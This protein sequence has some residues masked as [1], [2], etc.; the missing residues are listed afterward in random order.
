MIKGAIMQPQVSDFQ[1][2]NGDAHV[3]KQFLQAKN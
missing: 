3:A 1:A 2:A